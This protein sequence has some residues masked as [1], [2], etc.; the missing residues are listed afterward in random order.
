MAKKKTVKSGTEFVTE[1]NQQVW[2]LDGGA[3]TSDGNT[4]QKGLKISDQAGNNIGLHG[5]TFS[6]FAPNNAQDLTHGNKFSTTAGDSFVTTK[7]NKEERSHGDFTL[8]A[9]SQNFFT[10]TVADEW[11]EA[12][13]EIA[14]AKASPE[15]TYDAIGNNSGVVHAAKG[16]PDAASGAV[17]GGSYEQSQA[18]TDIP[19]LL[20]SKAGEIGNIERQMGVGGNI[21]MMTAKHL[22]LQAGTKAVTF[23]SGIIVPDGKPVT[24]KVISEDGVLKKI[25]AS[26]PVYESKDT[27]G[28]VPFGDVHISAGTKLNMNSGSGGVSIKSAGEV[29]LNTTG[30]LML[31]GA[32]VAIG[33]GTSND[34][35]R[36]TIITDKDVLIDSGDLVA[37]NGPNINMFASDQITHITPEA[38]YTGNLHVQG[39]LTV[40]GYIH[41]TGDIVA[42]VG[43]NNISLLK[44]THAQPADSDGNAQEDTKKP[45][46]AGLEKTFKASTA[47]AQIMGVESVKLSQA[48]SLDIMAGR[49][50]EFSKG[51]D[52]D[53]F[54]SAEYGDG[55]AGSSN[56]VTGSAS[57]VNAN[58]GADGAP[59]EQLAITDDGT[60]IKWLSHVDPR[61]KD[62]VKQ[63]LI[64]MSKQ[65]G[66]KLQVTSGYRSPAYNKKVGGVKK[67]QHMEGNAVDI[68]QPGMNNKQRQEF[69]QAAID[70]GFRGIGIYNS[71]THLDIRSS[72]AAWGANGSR[73]GLPKYPWALVTLR[74]N[75][76][77]Y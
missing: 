36:V 74:A 7:S 52:P 60:N 76:Y 58:D 69:I 75:G 2:N 68:L 63:N 5:T 27:S 29:N 31:G 56:P 11:L 22:Y 12:N 51:A 8:I 61:V 20:E 17:Q 9:G 15:Q 57:P 65:L 73:T 40:G 71:F 3:I 24:R 21:K 46:P 64:A 33:G 13:K 34:S 70:N 53:T 19:A 23:D 41:A 47:V 30:R 25:K 37:I 16:T 39:N 14:A 62:Q 72:K 49:A 55:G 44:H 35:G 26:V 66:Y 10:G 45:S 43:S 77:N 42:G 67:S 1:R 54:E 18:H 59:S 4:G 32:E 50:V 48:K 28:A 38:V 6:M